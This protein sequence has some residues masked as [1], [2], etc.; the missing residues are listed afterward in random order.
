MTTFLFW[1]L[2][3]KPLEAVVSR[4]ARRHEVDVVM[5]VESVTSPA[6]LLTSLNPPATGD[7]HYV[8]QLGCSKVELLTRFPASFIPPVFETDR[9]TIRHLQLPG[10]VDILLAINHFPSKLHWDD[11]S[12]AAESSQLAFDIRATEHRVGLTRTVVVG[13]L[14][15]N[16]FEDGV[17]QA[18]GL[19]AVMSRQVAA[20]GS[21]TVQE[22]EYPFFYNPMWSLF[23]DA[24]AG[25]PGTYFYRG[26]AQHRVFFWN[27]FDQVLV[28]PSLLDRF[29]TQ[30]VQ[31]LDTDGE[32]LFLSQQGV[33]N[34]NIVSDHLPILFKLSL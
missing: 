1:N 2:N 27:M 14:N 17:V 30:D 12:Q 3:R 22:R 18:N 11:A 15:M 8:P 6:V 13:D 21:R 9:L 10:Q 20:L 34:R 25:P 4:L 33:P 7:Y 5:L 19:H 16:P 28:R 32:I 29:Q 26:G 24:T 31:I 23:G